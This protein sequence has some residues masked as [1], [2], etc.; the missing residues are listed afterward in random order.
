MRIAVG[1]ISHETNTFST[2]K[3]GLDD[4][5][6]RR[7]EEIIQG[8]F[9]SAYHKEGIEFVPT[10][11]AGA[12]PHGL[13]EKTA[14]VK[15]KEELLAR[16]ERS[17]P[18]RRRGGR[19]GLPVDGIYLMLHGAME[20]EEVGDGESDLVGAIRALVGPDVLIS[21]SL[22]LH[23]NIAPALVESVDILTALRTAP[24][25]DGLQT[26]QRALD[27]LIRCF[28]EN[29]RPVSVLIKPPLLLP[30]EFA[31]TEVEPAKSL[32]GMLEEIDTVEGIL[33]SSLLVGCAWTDSPYTSTS[34]IVTAEKD[35]QLAQKCAARLAEAV[36][37]QRG[38][39][40][41]DVETASV[42]EAISKALSA[43]ESTVFISDSGDNITAGGAGDITLFVEK[44]LRAGAS[45]AVVA[46]IADADAVARCAKVG[47]GA[48]L[49][50]E[51]GG[52]LD[53]INGSPLN[54]TGKVI[55]LSPHPSEGKQPSL[56]VL[57][58][59]GVDIVLT[60]ARQ[61]FTTLESFRRAG[62]DALKRKIVVVKLGYLFPELRDNA[63]K[64]I[65]A[66]SPG[67]TD[68][69]MEMLPFQ[70]VRRPIFPLDKDFIWQPGE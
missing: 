9:W 27:L 51:I 12:S 23:G 45:D 35:N 18:P 3:T 6:V 25:R 15:L 62:I 22:D 60:S 21:C 31:V 61:A 34:V 54:V 52:K 56:A 48:S 1:G 68:L 37:K 2:L 57:R 67:F 30:G 43:S 40:K 58:V 4:F 65:M 47:E 53:K 33:T 20:V 70:R 28:K 19:G 50:M 14:Y 7:G 39:F 16:L 66:L 32:Y 24:H 29:I 69:R 38:E 64:T 46:G 44:L 41:T 5:Y 11:T 10:L 8:E 55:H 42:D 49:T 17:L 59:E 63:P 36:W 26:R 13:V